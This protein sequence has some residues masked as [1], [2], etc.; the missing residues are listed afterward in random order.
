[1][2]AIAKQIESQMSGYDT[3]EE[4]VTQALALIKMKDEQGYD[5]FEKDEN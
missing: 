1:M 3:I 2:Q 5:V 4:L